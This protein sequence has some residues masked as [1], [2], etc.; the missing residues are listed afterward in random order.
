M[1][2]HGHWRGSLPL[3][4]EAP[5]VTPTIQP[6]TT[7][8]IRLFLGILLA[9][10]IIMPSMVDLLRTIYLALCTR[11]ARVNDLITFL[12]C[13]HWRRHCEEPGIKRLLTR[14]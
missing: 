2:W 3:S 9:T 1:S 4:L 5:E 14:H 8:T 13:R 12:N 6:A 7:C 10:L 11:A